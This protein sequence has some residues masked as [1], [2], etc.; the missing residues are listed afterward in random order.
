LIR[1]LFFSTNPLDPHPFRGYIIKEHWCSKINTTQFCSDGGQLDNL[2]RFYDAAKYH[3]H[4]LVYDGEWLYKYYYFMLDFA[5]QINL[6]NSDNKPVTLG[7]V[8]GFLGYHD[9]AKSHCFKLNSLADNHQSSG[10]SDASDL[11]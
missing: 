10:W 6:T 8:I 2:R 4:S 5:R 1:G 7:W 3:H 11:D 9:L